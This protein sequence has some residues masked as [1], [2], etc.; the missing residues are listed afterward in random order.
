MPKKIF[1]TEEMADKF[2][3]ANDV[4]EELAQKLDNHETFFGDNPAF[5]PA[6]GLSFEHAMAM[7]GYE[8]ARENISED[9]LSLPITEKKTLLANIAIECQEREEKCRKGL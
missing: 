5:P 1:I 9:L 4:N 7:R 8:N 2:F 6:E 3:K